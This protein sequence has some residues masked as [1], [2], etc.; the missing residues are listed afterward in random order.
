M[1][2]TR[3]VRR[4]ISLKPQT[5]PESVDVDATVISVKGVRITRGD[6][7]ICEAREKKR[8][9]NASN[10]ETRSDGSAED[11]RG[12][13]RFSSTDRRPERVVRRGPFISMVREMPT[14][15]EGKPKFPGPGSGRNPRGNPAKASSATARKEDANPST[16]QLDGNSG[17]TGLFHCQ[18]RGA[19]S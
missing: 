10:V 17:R 4:P 9:R 6:L 14:K 15:R 8:S 16:T 2:R 13:S 7:P 3:W 11:S 5:D 19:V 18:T 12:H 1:R